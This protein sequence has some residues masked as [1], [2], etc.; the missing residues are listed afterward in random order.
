MLSNVPLNFVFVILS[1]SASNALKLRILPNQLAV[2]G[3]KLPFVVGSE[4]PQ[5][6]AMAQRPAGD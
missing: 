6:G 1:A 2:E 4:G 3:F 5:L